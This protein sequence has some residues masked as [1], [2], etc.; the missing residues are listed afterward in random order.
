MGTTGG[1]GKWT[2]LSRE[3]WDA[4]WDV[5]TVRIDYPN[6]WSPVNR[7]LI[8]KH[9]RRIPYKELADRRISPEQGKQ[10]GAWW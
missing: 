2:I 10:H 4:K 1:K 8:K 7:Y 9:E 5:L 6:G 3:Y